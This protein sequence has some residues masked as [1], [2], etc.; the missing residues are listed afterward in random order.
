MAG[1]CR[2][3][4]QRFTDLSGELSHSDVGQRRDKSVVM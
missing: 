1:Y 4:A 3:S 2:Q